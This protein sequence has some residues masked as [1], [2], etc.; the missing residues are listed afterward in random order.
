ME[1]DDQLKELVF[2]SHL[3]HIAFI[4]DGNGRWALKRGKPREFGHVKGAET[5]KNVI[6]WCATSGI[7]NI[8]VYAFS[9]ENWSRPE[10]EVKKIISLLKTYIKTAKKESNLNQVKF[11]F[12]GNLK[13]LDAEMVKKCKD[14]E[15]MTEIY[16]RSTVNIAFN[17]GS[18]NEITTAINEMISEGYKNVTEEDVTN[19]LF[20]SNCPD[21]DLIIRTAGEYRLS[22]FLLWQSAYSELYFTDCLWPDFSKSDLLKAIESFSNRKRKYGKI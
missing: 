13:V 11:R 9:T 19:H 3:E 15:K 16:D 17:Y 6:R 2:S 12:I 22:N 10:K 20:T 21:P 1:I 7:K 4:M 14:L 8:T 5:F 18:R